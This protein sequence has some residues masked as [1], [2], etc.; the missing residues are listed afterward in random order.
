MAKNAKPELI[1]GKKYVITGAK[2]TY[3]MGCGI[4]FP[5]TVVCV[6]EPDGL[7]L[8]VKGYNGVESWS[9]KWFKYHMAEEQAKIEIYSYKGGFK[10]RIRAA[11]GKLTNHTHNSVAG[12]KKGIKALKDAL[13]T[14]VIKVIKK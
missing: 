9:A 4:K 14:G 5:Q 6:R 2:S 12:A 13:E 11:N 3:P 8:R 1:Q 10:F 7:W